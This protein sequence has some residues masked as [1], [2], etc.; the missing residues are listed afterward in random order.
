MGGG[1]YKILLWKAVKGPEHRLQQ[2][3]GIWQPSSSAQDTAS[4][5]E[6]QKGEWCCQLHPS[7]TIS[8]QNWAVREPRIPG[9]LHLFADA[10]LSAL[11]L[12]VTPPPPFFPLET[13]ET[14]QNGQPAIFLSAA[15]SE[16]ETEL[17]NRVLAQ[18]SHIHLEVL[19][20]QSLRAQKE[21]R[22]E[23]VEELKVHFSLLTTRAGSRST[24]FL[25]AW[26]DVLISW[27]IKFLQQN[28]SSY[29]VTLKGYRI[30]TLHSCPHY[31][32]TH[33][34]GQRRMDGGKG[35]HVFFLF[36]NKEWKKT[37]L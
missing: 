26:Q 37:T 2:W 18:I 35:L 29:S 12:P 13:A 22:G 36:F 24:G 28:T 9:H 19:A 5:R 6:A 31:L 20:N 34:E 32:S 33:R 1:K 30:V 14:S 3:R 25:P 27:S 16:E 7:R 4:L 21:I 23:G 11:D 10:R 15:P 8:A 17:A